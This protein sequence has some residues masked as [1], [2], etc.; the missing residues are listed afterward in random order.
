MPHH[1]NFI[2]ETLEMILEQVHISVEETQFATKII[3]IKLIKKPEHQVSRH[4]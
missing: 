3:V 2:I 1:L 4:K